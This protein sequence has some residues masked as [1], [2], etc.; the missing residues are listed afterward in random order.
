MPGHCK[1]CKLLSSKGNAFVQITYR[2]Y[3]E[4]RDSTPNGSAPAIGRFCCSKT[5]IFR[6]IIWSHNSG[7][8]HQMNQPLLQGNSS[9]VKPLFFSNIIWSHNSL[10]YSKNQHILEQEDDFQTL[11]MTLN[12]PM[13]MRHSNCAV[14]TD[15]FYLVSDF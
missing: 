10:L 11:V 9:V 1:L 7:I 13:N 8:A 3:N 12:S 4:K 6:N 14:Y 15:P 5:T 2:L